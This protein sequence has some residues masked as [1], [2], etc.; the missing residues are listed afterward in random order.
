[1]RALIT[2]LFLLGA[3]PGTGGA[4]SITFLQDG[5]S[6]G[7]PLLVSFT[8]NDDDRDGALAASELTEFTATWTTPVSTVTTWLKPN[9][10]P[11]GFFFFGLD[12]YV[13]FVRNDDYSLVNTAFGGETIASVFDRF[14]FPVDSTTSSP[15]PVPEPSTFGLLS[16]S[17][18]AILAFVR[19]KRNQ[20]IH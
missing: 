19:R 14:L 15:S 17:G 18:A 20:H 10:E 13:F 1:M 2:T 6:L 3:L 16:V 11:D 8:G 12:D 4:T 7:G 5:W 9:I